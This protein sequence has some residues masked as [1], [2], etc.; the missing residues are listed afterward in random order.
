MTQAIVLGKTLPK[1][2]RNGAGR[3]PVIVAE[4]LPLLTA[5]P[6][7]F[8]ALPGTHGISTAANRVAKLNAATEVGGTI[9]ATQRRD[10]GN[11]TVAPE[12]QAFVVA[13]FTPDKPKRSRAKAAPVE[14]PASE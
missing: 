7:E 12:G 10:L 5:T 4:A 9:Q 11:G 2:K 1:V 3:K 8:V 14:A 6:G 13:M